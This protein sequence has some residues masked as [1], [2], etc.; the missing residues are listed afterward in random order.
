MSIFTKLNVVLVE[1][2][3]MLS[4]AVHKL[5]DTILCR[6]MGRLVSGDS[7][8]LR[9]AVLAST[10]THTVVLDL[11]EVHSMDAAGLG[12]LLSLREWAQTTGAK[13]QLMNLTPSVEEVF[14]LT[15]LKDV[16]EFCSVPE[17]LALMCQAL[18]QTRAIAAPAVM[19]QPLRGL[20][21]SDC[22]TVSD[23][24]RAIQFGRKLNY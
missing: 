20:A 5:R 24:R 23:S 12:V 2:Q 3:T 13:F 19:P 1:E 21:A 22:K 14:E 10:R 6:C 16:F 18:R 9:D 17:M 11:A 4:F 7:E 15:N 8:S